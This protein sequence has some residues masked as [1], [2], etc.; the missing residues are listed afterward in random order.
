VIGRLLGSRAVEVL[1]GAI[2]VGLFAVTYLVVDPFGQGW[3][4]WMLAIMVGFA[5]LALWPLSEAGR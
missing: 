5:G 1:C 2:G 4:Y 3:E